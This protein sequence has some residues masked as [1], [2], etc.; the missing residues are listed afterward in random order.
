MI[1]VGVDQ[2]TEF[3]SYF[4]KGEADIGGSPIKQWKR[5]NHLGKIYRIVFGKIFPEF[6]ADPNKN[7]VFG[8]QVGES[9]SC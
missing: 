5:I 3:V 2:K 6:Y 4:L 9:K 7:Q 1:R 8:I